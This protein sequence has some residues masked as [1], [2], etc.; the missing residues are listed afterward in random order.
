MKEIRGIYIPSENKR[1]RGDHGIILY[2]VLEI[3]TAPGVIT[4]LYPPPPP[5]PFSM[6]LHKG[7]PWLP[8]LSNIEFR[9][10]PIVMIKNIR[11]STWYC[12]Y[13]ESDR[14]VVLELQYS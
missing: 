9:N 8:N 4:P 3:F 14:V 7:I 11:A 13:I 5:S 2:I 1:I 6:V 10:Y 12:I